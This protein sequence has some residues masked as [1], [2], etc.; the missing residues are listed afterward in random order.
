[1]GVSLA[2]AHVAPWESFATIQYNAQTALISSNQ[3]TPPDSP[4][5]LRAEDAKPE[6][7]R[8]ILAAKDHWAKDD[9][10]FISDI[11]RKLKIQLGIRQS[12]RQIRRVIAECKPKKKVGH[13]C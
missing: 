9:S 6:H 4:N 13:A 1:M 5:A 11:A 8:W 7:R 12:E 10:Q 2:Q 3:G